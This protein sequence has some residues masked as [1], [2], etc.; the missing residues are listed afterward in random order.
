MQVEL[1]GKKLKLKYFLYEVVH[2]CNLNCKYCDHCSPIADPEFIDLKQYKN[3][4]KKIKKIFNIVQSIGIMGGEP[5]LHPNFLEIIKISRQILPYT[6]LLIFTNGICLKEKDEKFWSSIRKFGA[7]I[8]ITKYNLE[9][10]YKEYEEKASI[11]YIPLFYENNNKVKEKFNKIKFDLNGKMNKEYAHSNCY[12]AK[13]CPTLENGILYKCPIIP[14]SRHFNKYF[15]KN[16]IITELDGINLNKKNSK[17]AILKYFKE[18]LPFCR[19]CD[20][21]DRNTTRKWGLSKKDIKEW[22]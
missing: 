21:S 12:Q 19:Y 9:L 6:N 2:H 13:Y 5:L 4:L 1:I 22:T 8:V 10:N 20:V 16:M 15:N 17:E 3:D 14:A 11:H 7:C 18:P